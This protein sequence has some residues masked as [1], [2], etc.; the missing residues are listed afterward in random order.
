MYCT[1]STCVYDKCRLTSIVG[2]IDLCDKYR[3]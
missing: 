1:C 2:I 3:K